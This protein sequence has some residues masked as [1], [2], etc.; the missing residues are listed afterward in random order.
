LE[1]QVAPEETVVQRIAP[2]PES[3]IRRDNG[4]LSKGVPEQSFGARTIAGRSL[5]DVGRMEAGKDA[6]AGDAGQK[7][8]GYFG[9]AAKATEMPVATPAP[10]DEAKKIEA[11]MAQPAPARAGT[12]ISGGIGPAEPPMPNAPATPPAP[13]T[14]APRPADAAA[15]ASPASAN[16][17][18][19]E[20]QDTLAKAMRATKVS[21]DK[22]T[23]SRELGKRTFTFRDGVW[24]EAGYSNQTTVA[25]KRDSRTAQGLLKQHPEV[26]E[27]LVLKEPVV[28]KIADRWY[29]LEASKG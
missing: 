14:L 29:K 17:E 7:Q 21:D 10:I 1:L 13:A 11:A 28:L 3:E 26:K 4:V 27:I 8:M 19:K 12:S 22:E 18:S 5:S 9:A 25:M 20:K 6:S 24:Y 16:A 23:A 2:G 15:P